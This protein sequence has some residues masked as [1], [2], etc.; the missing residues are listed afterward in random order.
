MDSLISGTKQITV[1]TPKVGAVI[2]KLDGD[3]NVK[4]LRLNDPKLK[5]LNMEST[6][7]T[8][9]T[10]YEL[11]ITGTDVMWGGSYWKTR[12]KWWIVDKVLKL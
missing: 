2:L 10:V 8:Q 6:P 5:R 11:E 3:G 4:Y 12:L 1:R 9:G 7:T